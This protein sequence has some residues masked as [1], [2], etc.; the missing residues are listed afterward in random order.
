MKARITI[1]SVLTPDKKR[2]AIFL[3]VQTPDLLLV[4]CYSLVIL[5]S[6]CVTTD[7]LI[8]I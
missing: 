2:I 7:K 3:S 1:Q 6:Y 5:T 8:P 4:D